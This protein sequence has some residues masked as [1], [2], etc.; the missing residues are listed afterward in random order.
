MKPPARGLSR[1]DVLRGRGM[2]K[3]LKRT[4]AQNWVQSPVIR[5]IKQT[6][7]T[8]FRV[9]VLLYNFVVKNPSNPKDLTARAPGRTITRRK[10]MRTQRFRATRCTRCDQLTEFCSAKRRRINSI[11][12]HSLRVFL[13]GVV[14]R[15]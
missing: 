6:P 13:F 10:P 8:L 11:S 12:K 4:Q 5:S 2:Q 9:F 14:P 7:E 15:R 3:R 1:G